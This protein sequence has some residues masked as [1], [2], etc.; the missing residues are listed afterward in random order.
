MSAIFQTW[1]NI[2]LKSLLQPNGM[3]ARYYSALMKCHRKNHILLN[4]IV[5]E[6]N[7]QQP[8]I[9]RDFIG[10]VPDKKDGYRTQKEES[11][12]SHLIY[13]IKQLK[14][15]FKLWKEEVKEHL[16]ADPMMF[17]PPGMCVHPVE[18]TID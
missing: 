6:P 16:R 10:W 15:E 3:R 1:N 14:N 5:N 7:I 13:G 4:H 17:C 2:L 12:T 18:S 11:E 8:C 9:K